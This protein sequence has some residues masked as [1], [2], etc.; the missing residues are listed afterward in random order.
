[1]VSNIL[2]YML[3]FI[4]TVLMPLT[5]MAGQFLG[6]SLNVVGAFGQLLLNV[7]NWILMVLP[8]VP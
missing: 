5:A 7:M 1:M 2:I 6:N 8:L 4:Q 3:Q